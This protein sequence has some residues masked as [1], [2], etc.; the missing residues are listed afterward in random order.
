MPLSAMPSYGKSREGVYAGKMKAKK[1]LQGGGSITRRWNNKGEPLIG[2]GRNANS[3]AISGYKGKM[4]LSA[5]PSYGKGREGVYAGKMKAKKA[6]KGGGG[7]ITRHW[8]NKGEPLVSKG[9]NAN[10][11]AISGYKGKMPL[12][13]MPSYSKGREGVYAGKMKAKKPIKGGGGSITRHWNNKEEP[14]IGK[15]QTGTDKDI[16]A[17]Q[18]N[19]KSKKR[20]KGGGGSITRQWN[21]KGEPIEGRGRTATDEDILAYQGN[22]RA[23]G[24]GDVGPSEGMKR[25]RTKS[26][27]F[28]RLGDPTHMGLQREA[29]N[30]KVNNR[31]PKELSRKERLRMKGAEGLD[32]GRSRAFTFWAIGDPSHGGLVRS[33]SQAKGR[34]HPSSTY[35][36]SNKS[37]NSIEEKEQPVKIK[38]WWAKL[39]KKNSNQPDSVKEKPKR[40]RYD[41]GERSI[42]ETAERP[43][44]YNN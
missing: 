5:M 28:I 34:L 6:L 22:M 3:E 20:L 32:N 40:P 15:G 37:R 41:K 11:E 19:M 44:W 12:S 38:I 43:D 13:A 2:K 36:A 26:L 39:F 24:R 25:G 9:R 33:P 31:L 14:L 16:L 18:G 1:P 4:P 17:Y 29:H 30:K 8:N 35:T 23:A 7:S 27:S 10:S 42:W 21:N